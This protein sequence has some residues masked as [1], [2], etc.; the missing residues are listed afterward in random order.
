MSP[1]C[2]NNALIHRPPT[3]GLLRFGPHPPAKCPDGRR[4]A[5]A[6]RAR[7]SHTLIFLIL[8][9][10]TQVVIVC[11]TCHFYQSNIST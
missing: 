9:T 7:N 10:V 2:L 4:S 1:H 5:A 8:K 6:A 3:G 11:V